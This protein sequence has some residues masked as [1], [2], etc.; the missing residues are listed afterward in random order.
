MEAGITMELSVMQSMPYLVIEGIPKEGLHLSDDYWIGTD[1]ELASAMA[2]KLRS[3]AGSLEAEHLAENPVYAYVLKRYA[4]GH[5]DDQD[6]LLFASQFA[7]TTQ[8]LL[9]AIWLVKDNSANGGTTYLRHDHAG[10]PDFLSVTRSVYFFTADCE[11]RTETLIKPEFDKAIEYLAL[12]EKTIPKVNANKKRLSGLIH[13][14]RI[15]RTL[16]LPLC[17]RG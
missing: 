5:M 13:E 7:N 11:F 9:L 8:M 2:V 3:C 14:S 15:A 6:G 17:Q 4:K 1:K 16:Y 12:L 10:D